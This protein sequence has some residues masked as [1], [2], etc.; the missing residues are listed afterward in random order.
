MRRFAVVTT[1][2]A[3]GYPLYGQRMA[4]TFAEFWPADVPLLFY[5][6]G[7]T[8]DPIPG[9]LVERDLLASSPELVAFKARHADNPRAHGLRKPFRRLRLGPLDMPLPLRTRK[10][11]YRWNAVR[12][13]HKSF[14]I[15]HAAR[16]TDADVLIWIDADTLF[17]APVD[18][19]EL[20]QLAPPDIAAQLNVI[21]LE[22][23][24]VSLEDAQKL[25]PGATLGDFIVDLAGVADGLGD[26]VAK[27]V[28]VAATDAVGGDA[29]LS[30]AV[31]EAL[32]QGAEFRKATP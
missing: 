18:Q 16:Q 15:F 1:C 26:F 7:F 4:A 14:A 32:K 27:H 21:R 24:Q 23:P 22:E 13:A 17:F 2:H 3:A 28:T 8:A 31:D 20:E 5:S 29:G 12:F 10:A 11:S 25:Q 19:A 6:E 30:T 9:R